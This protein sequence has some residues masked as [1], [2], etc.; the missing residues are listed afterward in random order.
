MAP[1]VEVEQ[2]VLVLPHLF[3]RLP[4]LIVVEVEVELLPVQVE[5]VELVEVEL[6]E[7]VPL[8]LPQ[9][10]V[11]LIQVVLEVDL[12]DLMVTHQM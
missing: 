1:L 5:L 11:Q 8:M 9:L 10:L 7:L 3:Q 12:A 2:A 4:Q 6:E